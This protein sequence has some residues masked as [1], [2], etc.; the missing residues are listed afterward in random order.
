ML[1]R[2]SIHPRDK[3]TVAYRLSLGARAVAYG[4]KDVHFR[5]PYPKAIT[6]NDNAL[7]VN[8]TYDQAITVVGKSGEGFEVCFFFCCSQSFEIHLG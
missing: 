7:S 2:F 8:I 6:S 4:E 5:G 1:S 3:Y